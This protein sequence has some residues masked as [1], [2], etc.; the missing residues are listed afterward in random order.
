MQALVP[1]LRAILPDLRVLFPTRALAVLLIIGF[2]DLISTAVLHQ[3]GLIQ[4]MNPVMRIFIERSE[5]LFV[6]VK[7]ATLVGS[8]YVLARYAKTNLDFV[9]KACW[10]GS[11]VYVWVWITWFM[12]AAAKG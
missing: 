4:E 8:W 1:K 3:M 9:R 11:G 6:L 5:W 12:A 7:G 2:A 10:I